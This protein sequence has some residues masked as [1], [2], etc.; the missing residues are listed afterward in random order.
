M[1]VKLIPE[2]SYRVETESGEIL[3]L[4]AQHSEWEGFTKFVD[5]TNV[6]IVRSPTEGELILSQVFEKGGGERVA[7]VVSGTQKLLEQ[8]RG[9]TEDDVAE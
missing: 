4:F 6:L 1:K 2:M 3:G 7:E 5:D 8:I 9:K